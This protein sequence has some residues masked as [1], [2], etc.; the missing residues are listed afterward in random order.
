MCIPILNYSAMEINDNFP[1]NEGEILIGTSEQLNQQ[2]LNNLNG[3]FVISQDYDLSNYEWI[4]VG[5]Y[6]KPFQGSLVAA[7][8]A[9]EN[10]YYKITGLRTAATV[11]NNHAG[12]FGAIGENA[13]IKNLILEDV[14]IA[15]DS[16][17]VAGAITAYNSWKNGKGGAIENCIVRNGVVSAKSIAGGIV[18]FNGGTIQNC[19]VVGENYMAEDVVTKEA[20]MLVNVTG[21][22]KTWAGGIAGVNDG[23]V[24]GVNAYTMVNG[25]VAIK[26]GDNTKQA[27]LGGIAGENNGDIK[28]VKVAINTNFNNV[29]FGISTSN[30]VKSYTGGVAGLSTG[31]VANAGVSARINVSSAQSTYVGGVVGYLNAN[32][33]SSS[34]VYNI[35][36]AYVYD[37]NIYG[38]RVGGIAGYV[39]TEYTQSYSISDNYI[40]KWYAEKL[41]IKSETY[42]SN[43][44]VAIFGCAVEESVVLSGSQIGGFASEINRGVV[45]NS[46]TKAQLNGKSNAGLV[47]T[48]LFNSANKSGGLISRSY[49]IVDL[50]SGNENYYVSASHVHAESNINQRTA[51]FIDDY[52]YAVKNDHNGKSPTYNGGVIISI[53][54]LFTSDENTFTSRQRE[55]STLQ[56][57]SVWS[58][59][60]ANDPV[61]NSQSVWTVADG[62]LPSLPSAE[63]NK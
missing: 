62:T 24:N 52:Y 25:F 11:E 3:S 12:L 56:K 50:R 23:N 39:T 4:P 54:N 1:G 31:V 43:L 21:T 60:E 19:T 29:N 61:T 37:S 38:G 47:Y 2:L 13:S 53:G 42:N 58:S 16:Y 35:Q 40:E 30:N 45:Y 59:F 28:N 10:R 5:T 15:N 8:N 55:M 46:Y 20:S 51:G 26:S 49:A 44:K 14:A 7:F 22:D 33:E 32:N 57:A 34:Q 48:I 63:S 18:G 27:M 6:E 17:V 36:N 9:E 41:S